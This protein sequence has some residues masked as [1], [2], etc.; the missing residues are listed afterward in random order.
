MAALAPG[1]VPD[2]LLPTCNIV[3]KAV[4]TIISNS[5]VLLLSPTRMYTPRE[6]EPYLPPLLPTKHLCQCQVHSRYP[7]HTTWVR[8]GKDDGGGMSSAAHV[9]GQLL[10]LSRGAHTLTSVLQAPREYIRSPAQL[11]RSRVV[12]KVV[13][14]KIMRGVVELSHFRY[15]DHFLTYFS[16]W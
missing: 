3:F 10:H 9:G 8:E 2:P 16:Q 7:R 15:S 13:P 12:L 14:T 6:Q 4:T 5:F 1:Y 11:A